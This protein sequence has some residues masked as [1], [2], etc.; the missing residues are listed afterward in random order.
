MAKIKTDIADKNW[1]TAKNSFG[2]NFLMT[3]GTIPAISKNKDYLEWKYFKKANWIV[4]S[5]TQMRLL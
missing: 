4:L 2:G 1:L 5:F 3:N